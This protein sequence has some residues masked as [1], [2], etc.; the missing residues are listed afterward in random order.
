[1]AD[2][3]DLSR[4]GYTHHAVSSLRS[5][6]KKKKKIW[7]ENVLYSSNNAHYSVFTY[8]YIKKK[9]HLLG[10]RANFDVWRCKLKAALCS[11]FFF[12][13]LKINKF[14][15]NFKI[16]HFL[17]GPIVP[18]PLT[19]H[20]LLPTRRTILLVPV[21]CLNRVPGRQPELDYI[22]ASSLAT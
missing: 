21:R 17:K 2:D 3:P 13:Y 14:Q 10:L 7:Q 12:F 22:N 11:C 19:Q 16:H 5:Q 8:I 18:L 15:T 4:G 1:M 6:C 20:S 9:E